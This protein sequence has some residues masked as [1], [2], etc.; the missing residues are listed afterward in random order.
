MKFTL[1]KQKH[2]T[3]R[4]HHPCHRAQQLYPIQYRHWTGHTATCP[5]SGT[6]L[7]RKLILMCFLHKN[8]GFTSC[9]CS[10]CDTLSISEPPQHAVWS[11][12]NL[13]SNTACRVTLLQPLNYYNILCD[14]SSTSDPIQHAVWPLF[15]LWSN[16]A[17]C[18]TSIRPLKYYSVLCD[19][20]ST[21][22]PLQLS[23]L[24]HFNLWT[25]AAC[26]MSSYQ[27]K[28]LISSSPI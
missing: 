5:V 12:F 13:W 8:S 25:T 14:L 3:G 19:L 4:L 16:T 1:I 20:L 9:H 24:R 7:K 15:N 27:G 17:C 10:L 11:F 2:N 23:L 22:E 18:V 21:T 6:L 26:F 28:L